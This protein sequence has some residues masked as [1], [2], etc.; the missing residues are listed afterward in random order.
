MRLFMYI[1]HIM[2]MKHQ[3][4]SDTLNKFDN[5]VFVKKKPIN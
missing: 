3:K 5:E 2:K 1:C 4:I